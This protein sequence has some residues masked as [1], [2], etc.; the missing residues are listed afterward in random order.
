M[1]E[2]IVG[3]P[4]GS[5]VVSFATPQSQYQR[6]VFRETDLEYI[7]VTTRDRTTGKSGSANCGWGFWS[8][9]R[10]GLLRRQIRP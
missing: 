10:Y 1:L 5:F 3:P 9:A 8:I 7:I 2:A 4:G 6:H